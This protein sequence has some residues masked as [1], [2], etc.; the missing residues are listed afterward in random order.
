MEYFDLSTLVRFILRP[1][2]FEIIGIHQLRVGS[3]KY[4]ESETVCFDYL[5]VKLLMINCIIRQHI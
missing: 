1:L 3:W 4:M 5:I 2:D